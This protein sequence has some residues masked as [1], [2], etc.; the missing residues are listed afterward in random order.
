M[1]AVADE[2]YAMAH[3]DPRVRASATTVLDDSPD[4]VARWIAANATA[5]AAP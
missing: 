4:A 2:S 5:A 3:A 1:C